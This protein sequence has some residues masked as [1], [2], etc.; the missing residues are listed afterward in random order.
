M[1]SSNKLV[2]GISFGY[3]DPDAPANTCVTDR[4]TVWPMRWC[5]TTED[6]G[7]PRVLSDNILQQLEDGVLV[8]TLNRP[9][10]KNAIDTVRCGLAI[11]E[12]FRAARQDDTG[13]VRC[14]L[15]CRVPATISVP[16]WTWPVSVRYG[17]G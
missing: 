5:F 17:A 11:R 7:C 6:H 12:T 1:D 8:V 3:P 16:G 14:V 9:Q 2:F 10:K 15:L 4:A 13:I